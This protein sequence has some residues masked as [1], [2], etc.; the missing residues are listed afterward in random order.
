MRQRLQPFVAPASRRRFLNA[1][2][3]PEKRRREAG[4]TSEEQTI[5]LLRKIEI[6]FKKYRFDSCAFSSPWIF[7]KTC[8]PPSAHLPPSYASF[9]ETR[10]GCESKAF[11][12]R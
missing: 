3:K 12:S 6:H 10:A 11:T 4:A 5:L 7:L 8:A 2:H 9:V 1:N